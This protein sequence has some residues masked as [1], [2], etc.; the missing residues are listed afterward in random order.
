M[1]KSRK[2]SKLPVNEIAGVIAGSIAAG[3]VTK[4]L[5]KVLPE[6][7]PGA[8]KSAI[9][10]ALGVFLAGNKNTMLKGAG[11]GMVAVGA[12]DLAKA[13]IPGIGSAE[14]DE[15]FMGEND[16]MLSLPAD[17][18]ILALPADQSI[19]AG[20]EEDGISDMEEAMMMN[21]FDDED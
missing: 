15:L 7:I 13:L 19:L 3:V 14:I 8:V 20:L 10:V 2:T 6:S 16:D 18:S 17:Q 1:A 4:I 12:G 9:P 11:L 5:V 21:G